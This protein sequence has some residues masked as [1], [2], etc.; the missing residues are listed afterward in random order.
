MKAALFYTLVAL[1]YLAC[2]ITQVQAGE[3]GKASWYDAH[4]HIGSCGSVLN[5][6]SMTVATPPGTYKCG[7]R[8]LI[9]NLANDKSVTVL[10]LDSGPFVG[11]RIV[12]LS[13]GAFAE[14]ANLKQGVIRVRVVYMG[15]DRRYGQP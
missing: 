1:G 9:T 6:Y 14:I 4:G 5:A 7:D 13:R 11:N 2:T 8:L 10:R 15:R 3:T 12:D